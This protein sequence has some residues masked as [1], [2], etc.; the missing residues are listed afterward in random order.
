MIT[1]ADLAKFLSEVTEKTGLIPL[2][3]QLSGTGQLCIF[4]SLLIYAVVGAAL[5]EFYETSWTF[6]DS[7]Y[8]CLVTLVSS[9]FL[10]YFFLSSSLRSWHTPEVSLPHIK[11]VVVDKLSLQ[12]AGQA[13]YSQSGLTFEKKIY[14]SENLGHVDFENSFVDLGINLYNKLRT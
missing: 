5:F 6:L 14:P 3:D 7:F 12:S 4:L 9:F 2:Q 1:I 11:I 13:R 10:H 8:F